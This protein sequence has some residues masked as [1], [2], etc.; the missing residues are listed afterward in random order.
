MFYAEFGKQIFVKKESKA[1]AF[2]FL[3]YKKQDNEKLKH[4]LKLYDNLHCH[5]S[6]ELKFYNNSDTMSNFTRVTS[7]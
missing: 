4:L 2:F 6:L 5:I 1:D 7:L 3:H